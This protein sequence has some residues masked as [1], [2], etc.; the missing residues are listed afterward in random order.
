MTLMLSVL[1]RT[2]MTPELKSV[3]FAP[4]QEL[5]KVDRYTCRQ[6]TQLLFVNEDS[7]DK[8]VFFL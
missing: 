5:G 6:A 4:F 1:P 3:N 8:K 2:E 7:H